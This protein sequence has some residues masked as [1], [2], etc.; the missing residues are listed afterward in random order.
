M[1]LKESVEGGKRLREVIKKEVR[2]G[3][4]IE[5]WAWPRAEF[6]KWTAA[7]KESTYVYGEASGQTLNL[8]L[9]EAAFDVQLVS[10]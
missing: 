3:E 4:F 9:N 2:N 7:I 6:S 10:C 8:V 5:V 1:I